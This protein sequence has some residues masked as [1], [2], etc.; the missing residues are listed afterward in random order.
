MKA[1]DHEALA[2]ATKK[3]TPLFSISGT[4][5]GKVIDVYDGDTCRLAFIAPRR[6]GEKKNPL[7]ALFSREKPSV[8]YL[9]VRLKGY[10]APEMRSGDPAEKAAAAGARDALRALLLG[11]VVVCVAEARPDKYGRTL[12]DLHAVLSP[13]ERPALVKIGRRAFEVPSTKHHPPARKR[14]EAGAPRGTLGAAGAGLIHANSWMVAQGLG[15]VYGGGEKNEWGPA[16]IRRLLGD[17]DSASL[18]GLG[19]EADFP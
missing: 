18:A 4:F 8:A 16:E 1:K 17:S 7:A 3:T 14:G 10:D 15:K 13:E 6:P 12:A 9:P 19:D 5:L 11:K 2:A